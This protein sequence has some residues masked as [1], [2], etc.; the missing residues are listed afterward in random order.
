MLSDDAAECQQRPL[1]IGLRER[2]P[3]SGQWDALGWLPWARGGTE[4]AR[5]CRMMDLL[6]GLGP[7]VRRS[8][9]P[10]SGAPVRRLWAATTRVH[11]E[12]RRM[13]SGC[14][15]SIQSIGDGFREGKTSLKTRTDVWTTSP[16]TQINQEGRKGGCDGSRGGP[17]TR[18]CNRAGATDFSLFPRVFGDDLA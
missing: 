9:P 4:R 3:E 16:V 11:K 17:R 6:G 14:V 5:W 12:K 13:Q 15:F 2:G 18:G 8:N 7:G 1:A 10:A